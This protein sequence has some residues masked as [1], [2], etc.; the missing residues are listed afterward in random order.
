MQVGSGQAPG[1][2]WRALEG[3]ITRQHGGSRRGEWHAGDMG[4]VASMSGG[5]N[6]RAR[7]AVNGTQETTGL[8]TQS[9]KAR[10]TWG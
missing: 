5:D 3:V 10:D 9:P 6:Q 1:Q 2:P 7:E 8:S 4:V